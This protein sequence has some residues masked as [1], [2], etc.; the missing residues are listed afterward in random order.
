MSM[1]DLSREPYPLKGKTILITGVSRRQGIGYATARQVAAW[2]ASVVIQHFQPHDQAQ[3][4]GADDLNL[5]REGIREVLTEDATLDDFSADFSKPEEPERVMKEIAE[6]RGHLDGLVCN[7]A[8]SGSDGA[9]WELTPE[10]LDRHWAVNARSSILL[11]Q[12]FAHQHRDDKGRG[13]IIFMITGQRLG[14]MPGEVAY[15]ASKGALADL[16][17]TLSDQLADRNIGVNTVNPGP[18]D[19]GYLTEEMWNQVKAMFPLKRF[20]QP[21]DPARL[22]AWLLTDE[23]AWITGQII[24]SEG[25]FGR[26]RHS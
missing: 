22:I 3:P 2:G 15:A 8:L 6:I 12:S 24:N 26:W 11:A 1:T 17:L 20:G 14:P 5:V 21:E 7:H 10:M 13:N 25:G 23:A 16:T 9:L 18:V 19:T 4:W